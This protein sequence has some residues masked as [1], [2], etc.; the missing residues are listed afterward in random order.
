MG[1]FSIALS[2][3]QADTTSLNVIGNNL[4][5]LNTSGYKDQGTTFEDLFYQ[6]IGS[7]GSNNPL[8]VGS[9]TRVSGTTTDFTQGSILPTGQSTDMALSGDG[10]F[11]VNQNGTQELT[12]SG[13]FQ[14]SQD[15]TLT[16]KDGA[17]VMGYPAKNGV[18]DV[19]GGIGSINLPVGVTQAAQATRS[20]SVTANLDASAAVGTQFTTPVKI[21]DSLGNS[22]QVSVTYTKTAQGSWD[23]AVSLPA[24][25]A[26][27]PTNNTG[28]LTFDS[29]GVLT[30]PTG[31]ITGITFPGLTD[32]A[33]DLN[34]SL[35]LTG[36]ASGS[37]TI[38]QTT[39]A[40]SNG[41]V[42]Q[43]G[44]ASGTYTGFTVDGNGVVTAKFNNDHTEVVGQVAVATV[45]N[46]QG[47]VMMGHNN[48]ATTAA[49]GDAVIG[50][51]GTGGRATIE[52]SSLEQSNVDISTEFANLIV[53]Q[54]AFEANSKTITT[55]DSLT[56]T[57]LGMI[58]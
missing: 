31:P 33:S 37:P 24:G 47:L 25:E 19:N 9:G 10:F 39:A 34:F 55:F 57:T 26:G 54:R 27:A 30:S 2:G 22:H 15:G 16:T 6:Q 46:T 1:N 45:T 5:N 17:L 58:R 32:G 23:Y 49:S 35:D 4:A 28:T 21:Y 20:I 52:D 42:L 44:Y 12:R 13:D 51:A 3:L 11:V 56:Q 40:S 48:Y 53:A 50:V 38:T 7:S 41:D 18:P 14:L 36:G 8:Q 29:N 43:D